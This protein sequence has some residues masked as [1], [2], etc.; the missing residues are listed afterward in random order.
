MRRPRGYAGRNHET[1]GSDI[2]AVRRSLEHLVGEHATPKLPGQVLLPEQIARLDQV[3]AGDW[4]P[5]A[6]LL[7]LME[8]IDERLGRYALV[9]MGRTVFSL[10]HEER[11][12]PQAAVGRD[13]VYGMDAMYHAV[14]RGEQIGGWKVLAFGPSRAVL[15]KTTPHHCAMEEGILAQAL[16]AVGA[17]A[18]ITQEACLRQDAD[19]CRFVLLPST[20]GRAWTG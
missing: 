8:R 13:I 19:A 2:L 20:S 18:V 10:L 12:A 6:W 11:V 17:P 14:N 15:E 1:I 7:E 16:T 5:I 9:K 4:Y 3:R